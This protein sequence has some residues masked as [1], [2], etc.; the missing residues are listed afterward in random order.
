MSPWAAPGSGPEANASTR[1]DLV[2]VPVLP[3]KDGSL[4]V[5]LASACLSETWKGN[6]PYPHWQDCRGVR[7]GDTLTMRSCLCSDL[8]AMGG[9]LP[10]SAGVSAGAQ[11]LLEWEWAPPS[12]GYA[13]PMALWSL[14][15]QGYRAIE[16]AK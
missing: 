9:L 2:L 11:K 4:Q 13:G 10:I 5:S 16:H 7:P 14:H 15:Y 3:Q 12:L 8:A 1:S 6:S